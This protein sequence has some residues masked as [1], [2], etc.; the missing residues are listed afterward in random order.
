[1]FCLP[2]NSKLQ[3]LVKI[4]L[5]LIFVS[6]STFTQN[7]PFKNYTTADGLGH[8][9]VS[10]IFRDSRGFLW[11]CTGEG[12][13]RFDG[14]EFKNYTQAEG[15]P[16]RNVND[17]LELKNGKYL[18]AT[19]DG[20]VFFDPK[21]ESLKSQTENAKN[22]PMFRVFRSK[23]PPFEKQPFGVNS[24]YQKR[25][26]EILAATFGVLFRLIEQNGEWQFE[27][28]EI[29]EWRGK[30]LEFFGLLEDKHGKMW[31]ATSTGIWW[32]DVPA[33]EGKLLSFDPVTQLMEDREGRI[34]AGIGDSPKGLSFF[35]Y[36]EGK[37]EPV[38][39]RRFT[40]KDGLTDDR[41]IHDIFE[42][43][44]GKILAGIRNGIC[45]FQPDAKDGEP[46]FRRLFST[47]VV[48]LGEDI[49]GNIWIG[50][51]SKGAFK[52]T[53]HGFVFFDIP[54]KQ[55][56]ATATSIFTDPNGE[57]YATSSSFDLLHFEGNKFSE[58]KPLD[59][60][61]RSWGWNQIDLQ[62]RI[63]R[64]WWIPSISG[65]YRYPAV[66]KFEDLSRTPPKHIF[67]K[68]DGV[69]AE[70]IFRVYEDSHGDIWFS[71]ISTAGVMRWERKTDKVQN[72]GATDGFP[73]F[74][75]PTAYGEDS[76]GNLWIGFYT[77]GL[78]RFRNGKFELFS[79]PDRFPP[80]LVNTI[81]NDKNGRLWVAVSNSGL[82]RV[83]NFTADEPNFVQISVAEGLSSSQANC[84]TEDNLGRIYIGTA[85][86]IN[87]LEPK[88][89]RIKI[90]SQADGL[91][92]A[93]ISRCASDK[94][95]NLWFSQR[96]T[97]AK[98]TP[99][100]DENSNPPPIFISAL[101]VNGE[102]ARKLSELGETVVEN[103][104]FATDRH[105]IQVEFFGLT[106]GTGE[107]LRY[108]YKL[109]NADWSE[110]T[111]DRK[112]NFNLSPGEYNF[113]VRA[114][115][116]QG[117]T[118]ETP[119]TVNFSIAYPI[120]QR[121]WFLTVAAILIGLIIYTFYRY[122]L[123]RLLEL[124]RIRTRIATDLHDDIGSSLSQIAILSE[125]V[126]QKVGDNGTNKPLNLI[127]DTS[128][129]L[130]DSMSD[131][132][133]AINPS[134]DSLSDL[135][136]RMRR[137]ATDVLEAKDIAIK[138]EFP[139]SSP[140]I[141]L[142]A[143]IRREFYLMFKECVNNLAKHSEATEAKISVSIDGGG[144]VLQIKD[145]GKGF[146]VPP[147]DE[148]TTFEGFGGNGLLNLKKRSENLGGK[149]E[150]QSESGKGTEILLEI[151]ISV[152]KWV[153]FN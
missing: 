148:H 8:D 71:N 136:K 123:Q 125:V 111:T 72:L 31:A 140:D 53:R 11:F 78:G 17:I 97:I 91:P 48:A 13:S 38:L 43:S 27:K 81:Y 73:V 95:G 3:F 12:L 90:Y 141:S 109:N 96:F 129:E 144:L 36:P 45:E 58:I 99:E 52:L 98:L 35:T 113:L 67:D 84:L 37:D 94:E 40:T 89:G 32:F 5:C 47:D 62:S 106:F 101:R 115:N 61:G 146:H 137:F 24:I 105:Q 6:T 118:S 80:G 150:I 19:S 119:A 93:S 128:R 76:A 145:N 29:P 34:W 74:S 25:N 85:R 132:V 70:D 7:L 41:W 18:V 122:R 121:W 75:A 107:I 22:N 68:K 51:A 131:I 149:F 124:E 39:A 133:W 79:A 112:V 147:F 60:K 28:V 77:G 126:R 55:P 15:L 21:G 127:A 117:L 108:Q 20:I 63:D 110:L 153:K 130:V 26:G 33:G 44:D 50:T 23:D 49:G 2:P 116:S 87:R 9:F 135:T 134:K 83:D 10:K 46:S 103:L 59:F 56:Y 104:Q 4:S 114:V 88:T 65:L 100:S 92:G 82:V 42:T 152:K 120:W 151:P 143:D 16:H 30:N 14:Y 86:G 138:F 69:L 139:A 1:M 142:G 102:P 64:E 54:E 66:T 57:V